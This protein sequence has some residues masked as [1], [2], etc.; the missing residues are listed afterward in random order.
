MEVGDAVGALDADALQ[1]QIP[2]RAKLR[3]G[4]DDNSKEVADSG[5]QDVG[6]RQERRVGRS[7]VH[8]VLAGAPE[9]V[10]GALAFVV[11]NAVAMET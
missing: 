3:G 7:E 9:R 2:R 5:G 1:L 8:S 4:Y 6:N 10:V 11:V